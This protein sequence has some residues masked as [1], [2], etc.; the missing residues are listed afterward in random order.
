MTYLPTQKTTPPT[1]IFN[2]VVCFDWLNSVANL[3]RLTSDWTSTVTREY[4]VVIVYG[5]STL[6]SGVPARL[7]SIHGY[8][9]DSV[10]S[11]ASVST[12][13]FLTGYLTIGF[14]IVFCS[15]F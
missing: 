1:F 9:T 12:R 14:I 13:P 3:G 8:R 7:V 10:L 6:K 2:P 15:M 11:A 4:H 5:L